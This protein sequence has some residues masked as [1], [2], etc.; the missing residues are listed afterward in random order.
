MFDACSQ[1]MRSI[2]NYGRRAPCTAMSGALLRTPIPVQKNKVLDVRLFSSSLPYR[3]PEINDQNHGTALRSRVRAIVNLLSFC[4]KS[5][6]KILQLGIID[7]L[8]SSAP[9]HQ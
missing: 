8:D 6:L 3:L 4:S 9:M 5:C 7:L 1:I 2:R